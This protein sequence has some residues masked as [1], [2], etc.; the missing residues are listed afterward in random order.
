MSFTARIASWFKQDSPGVERVALGDTA[1][2]ESSIYTGRWD[3]Y[4]PDSLISRQGYA[5]YKKMM[6]D[7]QVKAVVRFKRDAI[8]SRRIYF[9]FAGVE[10]GSERAARVVLCEEILKQLE[11]SFTD[12]L[13]G[14]MSSL[15]NGFSMTEKVLKQIVV[16]GK[17]WVGVKRLAIKPYDSFFF[18][19]DPYGNLLSIKQKWENKEVILDPAKF[20][21]HVQNPDVDTFY[22]QSELREAYRAWFSKDTIIKMHNIHL[23][24]HASGFIWAAPKEGVELRSGSTEYTALVN[25][26]TNMQ[27]KSALILPSGIELHVERPVATDAYEKAIAMH[28]KAIAKALLV[29]N[30]LGISEQGQTGSYSQSQ[31]QLEAFLWTLDAETARLEE[32]LNEQLWKQLGDLNWGDNDYPRMRFKPISESMKLQTIRIWRELVGAGAVQHTKSDD[33]HLRELI[34]FP[35]AG[36]VINSPVAQPSGSNPPGQDPMQLEDETVIG[37]GQLKTARHKHPAKKSA[38]LTRAVKRVDFAVIDRKSTALTS[39]WANKLEDPVRAG[40]TQLVEFI[41]AEDVINNPDKVADVRFPAST[42]RKLKAKMQEALTEAWALGDQH[43]RVEL[44]KAKGE[45]FAAALPMNEEA[46]RKFLESRAYTVAGDLAD[47]ARKKVATI[48]YNGIKGSW[49]LDEIETAIEDEIGA[50]V[51]PNL[52]TTI[53]TTTFE[54][55]NEARF[56]YFTDPAV[57]DYVEALEYSAV[58]DGKTTEICLHLDGKVYPAD[59]EVWQEYKPPNH[60]NCRSLLVAVTKDDNWTESKAPKVDPQEGFA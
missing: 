11:G 27:T 1:Y 7:E 23:E 45:R 3:K 47:G 57:A 8:T 50:S 58:I 12:A 17:T 29:P 24:R 22:G 53:R 32:T 54:A 44:D 15:Y 4:N 16:D 43:A 21:R 42:M 33:A 9:E 34:G 56:S 6:L 51:L 41:K 36:T 14:I 55:I 20:I 18:Q 2:S 52:A 26:L 59:S 35:E 40:M 31:T 48:L 38:A 10:E 19:P 49:S 13:N 30:L 39:A 37:Q 28:D 5:V 25:A 46:A 60:F